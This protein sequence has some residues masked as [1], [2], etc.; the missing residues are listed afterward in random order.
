MS[1][2]KRNELVKCARGNWQYSIVS[3]MIRYGTI[4]NPVSDLKGNAKN[5]QGRYQKSFDNLLNR[6]KKSGC[7]IGVQR[8]IR[9]GMWGAT[10]TLVA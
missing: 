2:Q 8:G 5:Y 3:D 7:K 6:L 1:E 10:F 4:A 9:G